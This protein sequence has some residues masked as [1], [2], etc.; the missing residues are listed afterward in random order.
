MCIRDSYRV[1]PS[2]NQTISGSGLGLSI[3]KSIIEHHGGDIYA[4]KSNLGGL[5]IVICLNC[6]VS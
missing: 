2:R 4:E 3:A 5:A 1:D 6:E